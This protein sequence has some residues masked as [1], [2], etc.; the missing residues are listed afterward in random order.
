V[1]IGQKERKGREDARREGKGFIGQRKKGNEEME[2]GM[3]HGRVR[4]GR[5]GKE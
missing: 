3:G 2:M 4:G 5:A 1:H